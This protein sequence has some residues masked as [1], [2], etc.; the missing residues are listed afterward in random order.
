MGPDAPNMAR[1]PYTDAN[2]L[3]HFGSERTR[4]N[5]MSGWNADTWK[6]NFAWWN[7]R[8]NPPGLGE[9]YPRPNFIKS[10]IQKHFDLI[11]EDFLWLPRK[12]F[13]SNVYTIARS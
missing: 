9:K 1:F 13:C 6:T 4:I 2:I 5:T 11:T 10:T 8:R 7:F 12:T 3:V